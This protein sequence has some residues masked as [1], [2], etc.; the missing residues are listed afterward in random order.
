ME[1]TKLLRVVITLLSLGLLT[2]E[3]AM[4]KPAATSTWEIGYFPTLVKKAT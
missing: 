1:E 2:A 3:F 4:A